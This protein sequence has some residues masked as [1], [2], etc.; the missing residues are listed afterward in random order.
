MDQRA[1]RKRPV[2]L[3]AFENVDKRFRDGDCVVTVLEGASFVLG[4]GEALGVRGGPGAGKS[5]LLKLAAGRFDP[6][7]GTIYFEGHDLS[8]LSL[9]AR[10]RLWRDRLVLVGFDAEVRREAMVV[11][12][13]ALPLLSACRCS[14]RQSLVKA[15][16]ALERTEVLGCSEASMCDLSQEELMRVE[17][18]QALVRRPSLLLI[19]EPPVLRSPERRVAFQRFLRSLGE[20]PGMAMVLVSRELDLLSGI[21]RRM[22]IGGGDLREHDRLADVVAFPSRISSPRL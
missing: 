8:R 1:H 11:E 5:V 13:V 15:R 20:S 9:D 6:D 19:D 4:G 2:S 10:A 12:H 14:R 17:L 3:L 18:A 7:G 22:S 16:G 21:A